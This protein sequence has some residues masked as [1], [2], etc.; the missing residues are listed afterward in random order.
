MTNER[1]DDRLGPVLVA[2]RRRH[3]LGAEGMSQQLGLTPRQLVRLGQCRVPMSLDQVKMIAGVFE[4]D[5]GRLANMVAQG[6][7]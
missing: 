7:T 6:M 4:I 5:A 2:Y 3:G 1:D